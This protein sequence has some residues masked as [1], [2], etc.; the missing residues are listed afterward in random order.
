MRVKK[1]KD[2]FIRQLR[3]QL[4]QPKTS[5]QL[6]LLGLIAGICASLLIIAFRLCIET[7]Q[8]FYLDKPDDFTSLSGGDRFM[9]PLAGIALILIVARLTKYQHYRM[10]IPFVIYRMKAF[11]GMMPFK[12]TLNQFF[13]GVVTMASG[14]SVGREGPSVHLGAASTSFLGSWLKLPYN[15]IRTLTACGIAAGISAS[16]NTPLAAVIFVM[17]V[18]LREY[19]T[20]IFIP[21]MLAAVSGSILSRLVF[22]NSH[23][24]ANLNIEVLSGW[25]YPYLV[26]TGIVIGSFAFAFNRQLIEILRGFKNVKMAPRLIL[27]GF[28]TAVIGYLIPEALGSGL[29]AIEFAQ[30]QSSNGS[31][32]MMVFVCKA[33]LTFFAI[34]LGVPGGVIG[35]IFGLGMILGTMLA[36]LGNA[37]IGGDNN[38]TDL[39][40]VL[41]L[42]GLMAATL[43]APLAALV[44][45]LELTNNPDIILPAMLVIA[46]AHVFSVQVFKNRS[47]FLQQLE[48]QRMPYQNPSAEESLS[49]VGLLSEM[50]TNYILVKDADDTK[51]R[52]AIDSAGDRHVV[53]QEGEGIEA[54][55]SLVHYNTSLDHDQESLF[56]FEQLAAV[57][58]RYTLAEP[59]HMF[60]DKRKGWAY[61]YEDNLD[62]LVGLVS[63]EQARS[64]LV[65]SNI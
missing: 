56:D 58:S 2:T 10:G 61:V 51:L 28:I 54:H 21:V 53:Y 26:I 39:Y 33:M 48:L 34:G 57:E 46:T 23:E 24:L 13:A 40:G 52:E 65:H 1:K 16:F 30:E 14:F 8:G 19:K 45:A 59:F 20:H 27:A 55:F 49:K 43:N 7:V 38:Y 12:N 22:G 64:R 3:K 29:G 41:G 25:H 63:W 47:I 37:F 9:L 35:P 50:Q 31:L 42:A 36:L 18:V 17:E 11:Y 15:S 6:S 60:L 5:I 62:N 32:L 4:A 44:A